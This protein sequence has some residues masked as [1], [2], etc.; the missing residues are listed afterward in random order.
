MI[1]PA[2]ARRHSLMMRRVSLPISHCVALRAALGAC[3]GSGGGDGGVRLTGM[4][5]QIVAAFAAPATPNADT[6]AHTSGYL[7][8]SDEEPQSRRI[9]HCVDRK[10]GPNRSQR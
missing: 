10:A 1:A 6:A 5:A 2:S 7:R 3:G 4:P 8:R 9:E